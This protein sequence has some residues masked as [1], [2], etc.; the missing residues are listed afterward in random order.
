MMIG[1]RLKRAALLLLLSLT[2]LSLFSIDNEAKFNEANRLYK[3]RAFD[4]AVPLY[5]E[6]LESGYSIFEVNFNLGCSYYKLNELGRSRY[7][8]EQALRYKPFDKDLFSNLKLLYRSI[9]NTPLGG[10]QEIMNV[11]MSFLIPYKMVTILFLLCLAGLV[12]SL[13]L[14]LSKNNKL[15]L[16]LAFVSLSFSI[17]FTSYF[18]FQYKEYRK[19]IAIVSRYETLLYLTP[20][21]DTVISILKEG[22]KVRVIDHVEEYVKVSFDDGTV[23]WLK[24]SEIITNI[25]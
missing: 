9:Y 4:E 16:I 11:R 7:Y 19:P 23:G 15:F 1:S 10:E 18:Y 8:F 17:F 5:L 25:E 24:R 2:T 22:T 21:N 14:F 13:I 12:A 6:L 3:E 20:Y